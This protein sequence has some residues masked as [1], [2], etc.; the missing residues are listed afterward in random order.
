MTATSGACS[1]WMVRGC[2][3][4]EMIKAHVD[5]CIQEGAKEKA[6]LTLLSNG[7]LVHL[8]NLFFRGTFAFVLHSLVKQAIR[9]LSESWLCNVTC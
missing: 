2:N 4:S 5:F 7:I 6:W 9:S 1:L 8:Q 3:T